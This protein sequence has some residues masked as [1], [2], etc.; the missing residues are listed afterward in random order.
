MQELAPGRQSLRQ[1]GWARLPY[2]RTTCQQEPGL[3]LCLLSSCFTRNSGSGAQL[4]SHSGLLGGSRDLPSGQ[5]VPWAVGSH[6]AWSQFGEL[7]LQDPRTSLLTPTK[8]S[9]WLT[10]AR[11]RGGQ[12]AIPRA[13]D[14]IIDY[15]EEKN[16]EA[17]YT[18]RNETSNPLQ[19]F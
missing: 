10:V 2:T 8:L 16:P 19:G 12:G 1:D 5:A 3:G 17:W 9:S 13:P 6:L 18:P 7:L 4:L 14:S 15:L 11:N